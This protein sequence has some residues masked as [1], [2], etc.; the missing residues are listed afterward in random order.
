MIE[1]FPDSSPRKAQEK[2]KSTRYANVLRTLHQTSVL[3]GQNSNLNLDAWSV[4]D[5]EFLGTVNP[6]LRSVRV[7]VVQ[8]NNKQVIELQ[9]R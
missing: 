9:E 5:R 8:N 6:F 3:G 7:L 4:A 1:R 2:K